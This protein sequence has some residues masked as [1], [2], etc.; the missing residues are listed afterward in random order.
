MTKFTWERQLEK[1]SQGLTWCHLHIFFPSVVTV[2]MHST[3]PV[4]KGGGRKPAFDSF[5]C[6]SK[7]RECLKK[8]RA[9]FQM[10]S[11]QSYGNVS[12]EQHLEAFKHW[13]TSCML[14]LLLEEWKAV[15]CHFPSCHFQ[16]QHP[17]T[18]CTSCYCV[19]PPSPQTD[20]TRALIIFL[21]APLQF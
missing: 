16:D 4:E 12:R 18:S 7:E 1:V 14:L 6:S 17:A 13:D 5:V 3:L 21:T 10:L 19:F 11:E 20:G 8:S 2:K 15:S 9:T